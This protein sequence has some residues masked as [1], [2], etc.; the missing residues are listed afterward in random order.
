MLFSN[1]LRPTRMDSVFT[2]RQFFEGVPRNSGRELEERSVRVVIDFMK[3][4]DEKVD[5]LHGVS[6]YTREEA[7][8]ELGFYHG[9]QAYVQAKR[10]FH[11]PEAEQVS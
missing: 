9:F 7:D 11:V 2:Q 10:R 8:G 4:P 6:L 5:D 1:F 3:W